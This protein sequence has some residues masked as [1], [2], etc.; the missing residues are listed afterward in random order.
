MIKLM[1]CLTRKT[2]LT[3][4]AFLDHWIHRHGPLVRS[5][6]PQLGIRRYVQNYHMTDA[7]FDPILSA[8]DP[9]M[10]SYDGVAELW[11][12]SAEAVHALRRDPAAREAGR[13]LLE[14]ERTFIDLA[15]SPIFFCTETAYVDAPA[16]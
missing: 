16:R 15:R 7:R 10:A 6:A 12:D 4:E 14:D 8:R 11:Y 5:V 9:Q 2:P 3:R 13:A 1:F